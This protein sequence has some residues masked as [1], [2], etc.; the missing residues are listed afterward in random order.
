ML[1]DVVL[2]SQLVNAVANVFLLIEG[3]REAFNLQTSSVLSLEPFGL[4]SAATE[5]AC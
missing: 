2:C 4:P 1:H 3:L 5:R